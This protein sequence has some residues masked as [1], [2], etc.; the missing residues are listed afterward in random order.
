MVKFLMI[1]MIVFS[2]LQAKTEFR[3]NPYSDDKF[4]V[5]LEKLLNGDMDSRIYAVT[6]LRKYRTKIPLRTLINIFNGQLG[7]EVNINHRSPYLKMRIL[8]IIRM[9][10]NRLATPELIKTY[11]VFIKKVEKNDKADFYHNERDEPMVLVC[12]EILRTLASLPYNGEAE[13]LIQ[14]SLEH[15]NAYIQESAIQ[16]LKILNRKE[17][18]SLLIKKLESEEDPVLQATLLHSILYYNQTDQKYL[19]QAYEL[20]QHDRYDV[21]I[22][23]AKII[24]DLDLY[25][26]ISYLEDAILVEEDDLTKREM[27][28]ALKKITN[29]N[30][31]EGA[32]LVVK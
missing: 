13:K 1:F 8:K 14:N 4:K 9:V 3:T 29:L 30:F 31:L 5:W 10:N 12:G 23:I 6:N 16:S 27:F 21:R 2:F 7:R 25:F 11:A 28:A 15:P 20:L 24:N 19:E 17:N 32:D 22:R 18:A 26:A